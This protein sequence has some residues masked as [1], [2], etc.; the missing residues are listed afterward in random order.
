MAKRRQETDV[1]ANG[2]KWQSVGVEPIDSD[3]QKFL[4]DLKQEVNW[5]RKRMG[6]ALIRCRR[7]GAIV[8]ALLP[9]SLIGKRV[10]VE[11]A[12]I[13]DDWDSMEPAIYLYRRL[14][15]QGR[16]VRG[17]HDYAFG[18]GDVR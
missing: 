1:Y 5:N 16:S 13:P 8:A 2:I 3:T 11:F 18:V 12:T 15:E 9:R 4:S 10:H 7:S 6:V 17:K 14:E